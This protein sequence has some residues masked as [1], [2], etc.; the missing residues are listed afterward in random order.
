MRITLEKLNVSRSDVRVHI[1]QRIIEVVP[2]HRSVQA[3][4]AFLK[5]SG[6]RP[7]SDKSDSTIIGRADR[8]AVPW[9]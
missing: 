6:P 8:F 9:C 2:V 7:R 4:T 5:V 1:L 3:Y